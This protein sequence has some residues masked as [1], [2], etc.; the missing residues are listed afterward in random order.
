MRD[1]LSSGKLLLPEESL[2][3]ALAAFQGELRQKQAEASKWTA[4]LN[5]R[6]GEA[7]L[8]GNAKR[9]GVVTLPS[10][11]QYKVVKAG[12]GKTPKD[13]D[14]VECHYR[15]TL[16][17]GTEFDSTHARGRPSTFR[18]AS[19][20][21][22]WREALKLMPVGSRW[23][24]FVPPRLAYG[25]RGVPGGKGA[26]REIG[27]HATLLFEVELLAIKSPGSAGEQTAAATPKGEED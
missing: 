17:D 19:V 11:L 4:E 18:V 3:A 12:D 23:Q 27:P 8:A 24:L 2:R 14:T 5:K 7:F 10:G 16:V 21:P 20:I 15:G 6:Q 22:G 1:T 9:D 25:E 26:V 13:S